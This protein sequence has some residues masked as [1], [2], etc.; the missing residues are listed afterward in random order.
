[1]DTHYLFSRCKMRRELASLFSD[2]I[3]ILSM[4]DMA[5]I[6]VGPPAVSRYHQLK[7]TFPTNDQ[8]NFSDHDF[9]IP[10]YLLSLSGYMFLDHNNFVES[11]ELFDNNETESDEKDQ[12]AQLLSYNV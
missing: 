5:K 1:M 6:K 8:P 9:P 2:S 7:R 10:G 11:N 4:D 12:N 3:G